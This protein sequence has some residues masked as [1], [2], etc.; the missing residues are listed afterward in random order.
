MNKP[1]ETFGFLKVF[2]FCLSC[3]SATV[4]ASFVVG[5]VWLDLRSISLISIWSTAGGLKCRSSALQSSAWSPTFVF[6]IYIYTFL[7]LYFPLA[8]LVA[9][10]TSISKYS[11]HF[12]KA[13]SDEEGRA[14]LM[15][16]PALSD[17]STASLLLF[18]HKHNQFF[19][20]NTGATLVSAAFQA[21]IKLHIFL[22]R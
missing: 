10:H 3:F 22:L 4:T 17:Y 21:A 14:T 19:Y 16:T 1:M 18:S 6:F 5:S 15:S 9:V 8:F 7:L 20:R 13:T 2:P 11:P 12:N